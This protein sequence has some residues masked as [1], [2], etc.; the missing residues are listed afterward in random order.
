M[1]IGFTITDSFWSNYQ[2]I[3][4]H[5]MIPYQYRI[6]N[7]FI[8]DDTIPKSHSIENFKIAAGLSDEKFNGQVFQD[9]DTYKFI[10]A[11]SYSLML[12]DNIDLEK[13]LDEIIEIITRAQEH[14]GY[15][16][17]YFSV[18]HP[19][20]K[21]KNLQ[22]GHELYCAGHLIEAAI[23]HT[24]ATGKNTLLNAALK[25]ADLLVKKFGPGEEQSDGIP[26]HSEIELALIR[27][28]RFTNEIK[29][30]NLA[31]YF[32]DFR[33]TDTKFFKNEKKSRGWKLFSI[34]SPDN[35][36][37]QNRMPLRLETEAV[38]HAVRAV[39]LYT[40]MAMA[41]KETCDT[42]LK[43]SCEAIWNNITQKRIYITGGIGSSAQDGEAF[44]LDYD[45]PNDSAYTETCAG[46]GL[47]FFARAMLE[48]NHDARYA[49]TMEC[50]LYNLIL[51]S[52][53]LDG[54]HFFYTNPL[55]SDPAFSHRTV[56]LSH[57]YPKR[58]KWHSCACC[59]PNAARL[60]ASINNY[61][62]IN[63]NDTFYFNLFIEGVYQPDNKTTIRTK[64]NYPY[65]DTVDLTINTKLNDI[66]VAIRIPEW[67]LK[68][69]IYINATAMHYESKNGYAFLHLKNN[70]FV[71]VKL[72]MNLQ[73]IHAN[74][75][76]A[77]VNGKCAFKAGPLVYCFEDEDNKDLYPLLVTQKEHYLSEDVDDNVLGKYKVYKIEGLKTIC[78]DNLYT[79]AP[80]EYLPFTLTA[81]P[82][83]L[84][85]NRSEGKMRIWIPEK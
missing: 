80:P 45:L 83:Y 38:G 55:E 37:R 39:Y 35:I 57:I 78:N 58:Q 1:N 31:C 19:E 8:E 43:K 11:A 25:F 27:L 14:D 51:G 16:N 54:E 23:A 79:S 9:S 24:Q 34:Q 20:W 60:L 29:Y 42:D 3:V 53:N 66:T 6:L 63:D 18:V 46:V 50:V 17:T 28:Y 4:M 62:W 7:D 61:A 36:Y 2:N 59:P 65:A 30:L 49:D 69:S 10:E 5:K 76:L 13:Q 72:Y 47:I 33:G 68:F 75:R 56:K 44:T 77:A 81:I 41:A 70:D 71:T 74:P 12:K 64:T 84:W 40:A 32:I 48:L 67:S 73:R 26:G 22:E 21:W 85:N 52:I 82:Y 15:L